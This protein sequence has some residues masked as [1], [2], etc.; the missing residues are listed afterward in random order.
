M[1]FFF[2][3][4]RHIKVRNSYLTYVYFISIFKT[5]KKSIYD[6]GKIQVVFFKEG[7]SGIFDK[8]FEKVLE[9]LGGFGR[10]MDL[11]IFALHWLS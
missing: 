2:Y 7:L 11:E 1:I 8:T 3:R 10:R 9:D 5:C 4:N 6:G